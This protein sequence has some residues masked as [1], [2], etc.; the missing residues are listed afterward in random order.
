VAV[1]A[2]NPVLTAIPAVAYMLWTNL[3]LLIGLCV[4]RDLG[5]PPV[6]AR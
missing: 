1:Y 3:G 4:R 5:G 2:F 6:P